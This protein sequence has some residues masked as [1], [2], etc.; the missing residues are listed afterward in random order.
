MQIDMGSNAGDLI[1]V[2]KAAAFKS[3]GKEDNEDKFILDPL[4]GIHLL[5]ALPAYR[6]A[7][8]RYSDLS[9]YLAELVGKTQG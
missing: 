1:D 2:G 7:S 6:C 8:Y 4:L 5:K 3:Q 9:D